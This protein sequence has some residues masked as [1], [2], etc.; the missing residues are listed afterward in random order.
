MSFEPYDRQN[1][2]REGVFKK[3]LAGK[4]FSEI[5]PMLIV[6]YINSRLRSTTVRKEVSEDGE[7]VA[8]QHCPTTV[9]KEKVLLSS[10]FNMVINEEWALKNPCRSLPKHIRDKIPVRNKR[11][12]FLSSEEEG[13]LFDLGLTGSREHLRPLVRLALN[14]G[15]RRGGLLGIRRTHV[16]LG[17][18]TAH[19]T[20]EVKGM[21]QRFEVKPN[22]VPIVNNKGRKPYAVPLN[23]AAREVIGA[24]LDDESVR[25][26]LFINER[27][28]KPLTDIKRGFVKACELA[29]IDD[30]TFHDL[31]HTFST[32]LKE[33]GFDSA[34]R[35]DLMGHTSTAMTDDYTHMPADTR[36]RAV[37]TLGQSSGW[38]K[39]G[40]SD[41]EQVRLR[42]VSG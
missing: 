10:I 21:R 35:R 7:A 17:D 15:A 25:N 5:T 33:A 39:I 42:I 36:Q 37:D 32:R 12:R 6:A 28:G 40:T 20:E 11:E 38:N 13:R 34:T 16:K 2:F 14:T 24:L 27:T 9:Q 30:F 26:Y 4:K 41:A 8:K 19:I 3:F 23:A 31:R 1:C 18:A 22:N 29:G